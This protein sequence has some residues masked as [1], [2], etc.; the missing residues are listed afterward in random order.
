[1]NLISNK[2]MGAIV[3]AGLS[4]ALA[5]GLGQAPVAAQ[6]AA[7]G[8]EPK[9]EDAFK[10]IRSLRGL[11]ADQLNPTMVLFEAALGVGCAYCHD[12]DAN[13]REVDNKPQ[14]LIARQM[15]EMV[16]MVNKTT[17]AGN[18]KVTCFTCHMGRSTP[19][20]TPNVTGEELPPALGEDY[21]ASLPPA[22][23]VPS[24]TAI[25]LLDKY[26]AAVGGAAALQKVSSLT[27]MGTVTQRRPGRD[28]PANQIEIAAKAP[29]ME[30]IV[31]KVGQNENLLAYGATGGWARAGNTAP[32]DL[33][34][35]EADG[36][37]LEDAF[38]LPVQL[39]QMLIEPKVGRPEVIDGREVYVVTG[40]TQ[41]LPTVKAYFEKE[42]GM[43]ARLVYF[44]DTPFGPYPTQVEYGDF[45][46]VGGRKVPYRWVISQT[47]NREFTW[48]M[49]DVKAVAIDDAKFARPAAPTR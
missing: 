41:N 19:I 6:G 24:M 36:T 26:V 43:L 38:N 7:A 29:G 12:A 8:G 16:N 30:A 31:T 42:N 28:F 4:F 48:A 22:P 20:G 14:K 37:K 39:K 46:D 33:R 5:V 40:R 25:Q 1:M 27:A 21:I 18:G 34:K 10:N 45:R 9:M 49:Q 23:A 2:W 3:A 35:A 13:K 47:R 44:T 17:F 15:I 11:P 32:R